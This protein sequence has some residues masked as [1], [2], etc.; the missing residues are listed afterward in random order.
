MAPTASRP[1]CA[2]VAPMPERCSAHE[3]AD[4]CGAG[5]HACR[6]LTFGDSLTAGFH[7]NALGFE[8]YGRNL[9][10][11]LPRAEVWSCGLSGFSTAQMVHGLGSSYLV[12]VAGRR[13]QGLSHILS[14]DPQFDL[15]LILTGTND[16][17]EPSSRPEDIFAN[18][19]ALHASCFE[20]GVK[21]V[22]MSVPPGRGVMS[23]SLIDKWLRLNTLIRCWACGN[24]SVDARRQP[25][26][27]V[28]TSLLVP[29]WSDVWDRDGIHLSAHGS[30][31]LG[32]GLAPLLAPLLSPQLPPPMSRSQADLHETT[33]PASW[34]QTQPRV[35][36]R[37]ASENSTLTP[38]SRRFLLD[39]NTATEAR[40]PC[41]SRPQD[42]KSLRPQ[43]L[44]P[45]PSQS[46][47]QDSATCSASD[48]SCEGCLVS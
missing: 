3:I 16:L 41:F 19:R 45:A 43:R 31:R 30:R 33:A 13:G 10:A 6:I 37:S 18:I 42:G 4:V 2:G 48:R 20:R 46:K 11:G 21:T 34:P 26:L 38:A 28:D 15:V 23:P 27:F 14:R 9:A 25:V 36:S 35:M 47:P 39:L 29:Q 32:D 40:D 1:S 22:A 8:P 5:A 17:G 24:G 12:D 7:S 44:L